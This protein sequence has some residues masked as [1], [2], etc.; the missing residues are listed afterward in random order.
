MKINKLKLQNEFIYPATIADAVK[1]ANFTKDD[2][3]IMTQGEINLYLNN[4]IDSSSYLSKTEADQRY[5]VKP[6]NINSALII[7]DSGQIDNLG[8]N[9]QAFNAIRDVSTS[10][11]NIGSGFKINCASLGINTDGTVTLS[12]KKYD[13]FT[14]D[15]TNNTDSVTGIKNTAVLTFSGNSGLLYAKNTGTAE[16]VTDDMYKHVGVIDSPD[17]E[18]R[19]YSSYQVDLLIDKIKTVLTSLGAT[20]EQINS[21]KI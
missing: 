12:H 8:D 2:S 14:Y 20:Q 5:I 15:K 9:S 13:S 6:S 3:S 16:N 19:V 10:S 11:D 17:V 21:I 4:K 1:D 7:K 18:Q